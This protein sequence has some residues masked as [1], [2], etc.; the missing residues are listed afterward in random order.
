MQYKSLSAFIR[1]Q[2]PKYLLETDS[3]FPYFMEAYYEW[4]SKDNNPVDIIYSAG[5]ASDVDNKLDTFSEEFL[6]EYV[7]G[8]PSDVLVDKALLIKK[9]TDV[10]KTK[11]TNR[12]IK[13][14]LRIL[15]SIE[16]EI[17]DPSDYI[18][19]ASDARYVR[20]IAIRF[21]LDSG[22]LNSLS[23]VQLTIEVSDGRIYNILATQIYRLD[24]TNVFEAKL[25][26]NYA[27]HIDSNLTA[28]VKTKSFVGT[29]VKGCSRKE[30]VT[31]GSGFFVGD[32]YTVSGG[33]GSGMKVKI[34]KTDSGKIKALDIIDFGI[35]YD[36]EF[37]STIG[38]ASVKFIPSYVY[39]KRGQHITNTGFLSD[40][41]YLHDGKYYQQYS[42]VVK[43]SEQLDSY[44]SQLLDFSHVAGT[45]LFAE[46]LI[47]SEITAVFSVE[48]VLNILAIVFSENVGTID[49]VFKLIQKSVNESVS[50]VDIATKTITKYIGDSLNVTDI[51]SVVKAPDSDT[52]GFNEVIQKQIQKNISESCSSVDSGYTWSG[53]FVYNELNGFNGQYW[54]HGYLN[55]EKIF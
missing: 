17:I 26:L 51:L 8:L 55:N 39:E 6:T 14:L 35:N 33:S 24:S 47:E 48:N 23:N 30:I 2:F 5:S 15:F 43:S 29:L 20:D 46:Y 10:Y 18:F 12:A 21:T 41:S 38:N 11:G 27:L 45:K 7:D 49:E 42:Y 32:I 25:D 40:Q 3:M 9:I 54:K 28:K 37:T 13:F 1:S 31:Q 4:L 50:T 19:K 36:T 22:L 34:A 16:A 52:I 44:K 53:Y